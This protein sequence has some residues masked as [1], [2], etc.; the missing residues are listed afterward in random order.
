MPEHYEGSGAS[1]TAAKVSTQSNHPKHLISKKEL[2]G[3]VG[4]SVRSIENWM[5]QKRI[6]FLRLSPRMCKFNAERVLAALGRY[7]V[8]EIGRRTV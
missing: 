5:A 2:A 1:P 7:E 8:R 3:I 4:V 6:P